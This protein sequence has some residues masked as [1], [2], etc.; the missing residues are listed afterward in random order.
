MSVTFSIAMT[1]DE[2]TAW[3]LV[4]ELTGPLNDT[5][6]PWEQANTLAEAHKKTCVD[7][8][9]A[10]YGPDKDMVRL[11]GVT[12]ALDVN[13]AN[14]NARFVLDALG[15]PT[16]DLCGS[17]PAD[18]FLGRCMLATAIAPHDE[19]TPTHLALPVEGSGPSA[20][21]AT[22]VM[23]GRPEGY[24][25]DTLANLMALAQYARTLGKPVAWA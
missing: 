12:S 13:L 16:D 4:C 22:V 14:D 15:A 21:G 9:C 8:V 5:P 17:L 1:P 25:H 19:G 20:S 10:H 7:D 2:A 18:D 6:L 24:L 3:N 23:C 11:N